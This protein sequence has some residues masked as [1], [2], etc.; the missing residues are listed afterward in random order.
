V[1][2]GTGGGGYAMG[3]FMALG[4]AVAQGYAINISGPD[5]W[6]LVNPGN[7]NQYLLLSFASVALNDMTVLG[8]AVTKS[9]CGIPPKYSYWNGCSTS[10]RQGLT[11]A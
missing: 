2:Q 11:M 3:D 8:K 6:A 9:Y 5:S 10:G 1:L 7:T 4:P